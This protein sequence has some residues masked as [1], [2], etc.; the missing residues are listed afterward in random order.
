MAGIL[1][2]LIIGAAAM[3]LAQPAWAADPAA[4]AKVFKSQCALCHAPGAGVGPSL[5]GVVWRKAGTQSAFAAR[6][7]PA[8]KGYGKVWTSA[9]LDAYIA[10]PAKTVPGN[11]MPYPGLHDATQ[12]ANLV[13]YLAAQH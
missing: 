8:M 1:K 2:I 6:Y 9:N 11:K 10:N 12:L 13:A 7:S 4:G 3:G 5:S